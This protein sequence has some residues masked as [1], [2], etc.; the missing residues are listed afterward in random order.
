MNKLQFLLIIFSLFFSQLLL[1]QSI[2]LKGVV[3]DTEGQ[4]LIGV[5]IVELETAKGTITAADGS[6]SITGLTS[7]NTLQFKYIGM[8]SQEIVVD[9]QLR[10]KDIILF[11]QSKSIDEVVI[12]GYGSQKAGDVT[13]SV[14]VVGKE[15][16]ELRPNTQVGSLL[17]GKAAGVVVNP[18]SGKPGQGIS[19]NIRGTSSIGGSDPLYVDIN[20]KRC[21]F[22]S[23]LRCARSKWC[24]VDY[25]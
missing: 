16:L 6:Y 3:T 10:E 7:G 4:A 8:I 24:C 15:E 23:H 11:Y 13:G 21:F 2:E 1:S 12:V 17:Y 5:S 25:Y 19:I 22:S 9:E 20:L 18:S 14:A